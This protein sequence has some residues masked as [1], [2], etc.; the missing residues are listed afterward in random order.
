MEKVVEGIGSRADG[1]Q[2]R[3]SCDAS[4]AGRLTGRIAVFL[5]DMSV[6]VLAALADSG[7]R[8]AVGFT[9]DFEAP[10][11]WPCCRCPRP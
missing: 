11:N 7:E 5:F 2:G 6:A 10:G 9:P 1:F 3:G 8:D 4:V